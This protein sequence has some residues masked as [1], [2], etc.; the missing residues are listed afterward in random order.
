MVR[1]PG[2]NQAMEDTSIQGQLTELKKLTE[3]NN[4]ILKAMRRDALIGSIVKTL[5]WVALIGASYYFSMKLLTPY[6]GMLQGAQGQDMNAL[7][8]QYKELLGQ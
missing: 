6:L 4:R 1:A 5:I 8:E 7:F 2:Y 3:D